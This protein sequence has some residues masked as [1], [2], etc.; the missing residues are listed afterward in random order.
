MQLAR[1]SVAPQCTNGGGGVGALVWIR[2][3]PPRVTFV[4]GQ[5]TYEQGHKNLRPTDF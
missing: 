5:A 1:R 2:T 4:V 3:P